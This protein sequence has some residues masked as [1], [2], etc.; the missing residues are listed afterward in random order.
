MALQID[1]GIENLKS[2]LQ[3]TKGQKINIEPWVGNMVLDIHSR[4]TMSHDFAATDLGP[5][6]HPIVSKMHSAVTVIQYCTQLQYLPKFLISLPKL[7]PQ[8]DIFTV[9]GNIPPLGPAITARLA[10]A[11]HSTE[12]HDFGKHGRPSNDR[13]LQ[14]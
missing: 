8:K 7:L 14:A 4:L 13:K 6:L 9:L 2:Y 5:K 12:A 1:R 10:K 11:E 3:G